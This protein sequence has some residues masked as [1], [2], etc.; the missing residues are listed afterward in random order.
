MKLEGTAQRLATA[1]VLI[2]PVALGIFYLPTPVFFGFVAILF[3]IGAR[4]WVRMILP[5]R[6]EQ[7]GL[8]LFV[9]TVGLAISAWLAWSGF[10]G[11]W[12]L[13]PALL[14]WCGAALW[15]TRYPS[16]LSKSTPAVSIKL[17][18]GLLV[19]LPSY[20]SLWCLHASDQGPVTIAVL[21]AMIWATDTG[22]YF[23]GRQFGKRKL[24]PL[25]SP[26]KSVE[27][28]L[29]GLAAAMIIAAIC[30]P[31]LFK[32]QGFDIALFVAFGGLVAMF[33]VVGDLS[34]SMF[35][36]A[37]DVKDSG[38]LFPGHGGVLDRLDSLFS[39]SP[40][41]LLGIGILA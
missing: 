30:G 41:F 28:L 21:L 34:I 40:I 2:P 9:S 37:A 35:K 7:Q 39:A 19:L 38:T 1:A 36:R 6:I 22:G 20:F 17:L 13:I 15:I 31:W 14:W 16:G 18:I 11:Y 32:Y 10:G 25:V 12:L 23:V 3:L 26:K 33:S 29:G 27:G 24:A 4:E 8:F 5:E